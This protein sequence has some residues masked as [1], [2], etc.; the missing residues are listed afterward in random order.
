MHGYAR[1]LLLYS[2][3]GGI[4]HTIER[5]QPVQL[6]CVQF[7]YT[8]ITTTTTS[9]YFYYQDV[10]Y[11]HSYHFQMLLRLLLVCNI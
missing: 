3:Y 9:I 11:Y 1:I 5:A 10:Y 8:A 7:L 2:D 6:H 4:V